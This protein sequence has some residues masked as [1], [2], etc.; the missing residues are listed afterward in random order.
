MY[1]SFKYLLN[2]FSCVFMIY[3]FHIYHSMHNYYNIR[4]SID[5]RQLWQNNTAHYLFILLRLGFKFQKSNIK[6]NENITLFRD[7]S[8]ELI[9]LQNDKK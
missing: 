2:R 6:F 3:C 1:P 7:C 5:N 4:Y 8:C 9:V